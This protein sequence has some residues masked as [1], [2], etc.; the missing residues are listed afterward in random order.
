[1]NLF[2]HVDVALLDHL[3]QLAAQVEFAVVNQMLLAPNVQLASQIILDFPTAQY[4]PK[5]KS[6]SEI[7]KK[8]YSEIVKK[9][10]YK[11]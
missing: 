8:S 9:N 5:K 6:Y 2:Q 7:E 4:T 1:M 3:Q 11:K 10:L